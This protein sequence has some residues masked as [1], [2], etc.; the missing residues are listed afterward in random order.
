MAGAAG[1]NLNAACK[2]VQSS[3]TCT[4]QDAA[5]RQ[6]AIA[7]LHVAITAAPESAPSQAAML[8]QLLLTLRANVLLSSD[9]D[10]PSL[11]QVS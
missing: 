4:T 6:Q 11:D 2:H 9:F 10:Q 3:G 7:L 8:M 5:L 1:S